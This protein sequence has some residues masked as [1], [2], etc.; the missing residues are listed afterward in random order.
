MYDKLSDQFIRTIYPYREPSGSEV[1][2]AEKQGVIQE[3]ESLAVGHDERTG[4][5]LSHVSVVLDKNCAF[6]TFDI[7]AL[8]HIAGGKSPSGRLSHLR[9]H[10][11]RKDFSLEVRAVNGPGERNHGYRKRVCGNSLGS[12][13]DYFDGKYFLVAGRRPDLFNGAL[14]EG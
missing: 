7:L 6:F 12:G 11:G 13:D 10:S 1:E 5:F 14:G 2:L 4:I 3:G 8:D 9:V